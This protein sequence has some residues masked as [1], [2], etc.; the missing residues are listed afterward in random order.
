MTAAPNDK[1][2]PPAPPSGVP[3]LDL[4][5]QELTALVHGSPLLDPYSK[6]YWLTLLSH[7]SPEHRQDLAAA[8]LSRTED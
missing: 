6:R 2:R 8:L 7:L 4:S 1:Q 3:R 5:D